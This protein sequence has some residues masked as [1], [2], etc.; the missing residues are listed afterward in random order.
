VGGVRQHLGGTFGRRASCPIFRSRAAGTAIGIFPS[1]PGA[2][3]IRNPS[4]HGMRSRLAGTLPARPR[5]MDNRR[6]GEL[7]GAWPRCQIAPVDSAESRRGIWS[8]PYRTRWPHASLRKTPSDVG[9]PGPD[10]TRGLSGSGNPT[11]RSR[12]MLTAPPKSPDPGRDA[13]ARAISQ[14]GAFGASLTA[15]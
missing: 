3:A 4:H 11:A 1:A 12:L 6:A 9:G 10:D 8:H 13:K 7:W 5:S 15:V 2:A 14:S